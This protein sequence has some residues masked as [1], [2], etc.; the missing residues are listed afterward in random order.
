VEDVIDNRTPPKVDDFDD[1]YFV[2]MHVITLLDSSK[3]AEN[4]VQ[5]QRSN[6][7]IFLSKAP[8]CDTLVSIFQDRP[9]ESSWLELWR[10]KG[11]VEKPKA[12]DV[13]LWD[14]LREDLQKVPPIR[15]REHK[16]D[17]LLYEIFDRIVNE[18]RPITEAYSRRL[19]FMHQLDPW[20]WSASWINEL[21]EVNLELTDLA[22]SLRPMRQVVHHFV[23]DAQIGRAAQTYLEDTA[24]QIDQTLDD[25]SQLKEM[26]VTLTRAYEGA[27]DKSMNLMLFILSI[28]SAIFLPAQFVSGV[29]GM[30]FA[31]IPE[32][33]WT[34]PVS[35]Y[36]YFWMLVGGL[37]LVS[38][39]VLFCIHYFSRRPLQIEPCWRHMKKRFR[40][41][42]AA[43]CERTLETE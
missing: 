3:E 28:V 11:A 17:F 35:G 15:A 10:S 23:S 43:L 6:V 18:L 2:S 33:E 4:P 9:D 21:S 29:Y 16:A 41:L 24:D 13:K 32:L 25:L 8:F 30:N 1:H 36:G 19:G 12:P 31:H 40:R 5:T 42:G 38:S 7:S 20:A 34:E 37:V 39:L 26:I 27:Q 14:K 22:R